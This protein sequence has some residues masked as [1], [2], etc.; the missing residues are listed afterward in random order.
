MMQQIWTLLF[1][2]SVL[3][4]SVSCSSDRQKEMSAT[5]N[6]SYP[7]QE[8]WQAVLRVTKDGRTTGLI[9]AGHIQKFSTKK[10]TL[11]KAGLK[12][13]F[14]DADGNHSSVLNSRGGKIFDDRQDMTA[15]G[16]VVVVSDSGLTLF[17]DTLRWNNKEQKIH[18]DIP[19][20]FISDEG[21]TL[22]GDSFKSD[23]DLVNY[24]IENPHG[25]SSK[26]ISIE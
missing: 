16:N 22:Y 14:F 10:I 3:F 6:N 1:F 26:I 13:D 23:P 8:S 4:T 18:S 7:D 2:T 17:T 21:D 15:F 9:H 5:D 12:V 20:V 19:V 24:E 11:L 25:K